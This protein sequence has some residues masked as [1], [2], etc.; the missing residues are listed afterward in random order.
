M[1]EGVPAEEVKEDG[2][3]G[4]TVYVDVREK[5]PKVYA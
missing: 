2:E 4:K 3:V 1:P 5:V